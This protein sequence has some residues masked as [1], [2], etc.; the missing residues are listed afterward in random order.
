MSFHAAIEKAT[1]LFYTSPAGNEPV[2][3]WLKSLGDE[4]RRVIG[5]DVAAAEYGWPLGMPLCRS[6]GQGLY[7]IRSS[8]SAGRIARV[9]FFVGGQEMVLLHGFV[10]KTSK[11]PKTE[12]DVAVKRMKDY[13]RHS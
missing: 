5:Q 4:D 2:R 10:K 9:M 1:G 13:K 3:E 6:M 12:M 8:I 7:E 11:T